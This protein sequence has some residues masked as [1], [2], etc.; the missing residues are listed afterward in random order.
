MKGWD[1]LS[2]S[3]PITEGDRRYDRKE[4]KRKWA[5]KVA[6]LEKREGVWNEKNLSCWVIKDRISCF[7]FAF[8]ITFQ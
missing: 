8:W 6:W 4:E 2:R 7:C 5:E 1:W 3:G